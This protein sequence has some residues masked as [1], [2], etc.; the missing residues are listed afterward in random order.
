MKTTIDIALQK[1][2]Q[3]AFQHVDFVGPTDPADKVHHTIKDKIELPMNGAAVVIDVASGEV[4]ALVSVPT[5]DLNKYDELFPQLIADDLNQPMRDRALMN[6]MEPGST[7]KPIVGLGVVTQGLDTATHTIECR[8]APVIDGKMISKPR[9][10]TVSMFPRPGFTH[11]SI[12]SADPHPDGFL[13]LTDAIERSCN[14]YFVTQGDKLGVDGLSYW[15]R[16]FGFGRTTGIGLYE[17]SGVVPATAR[18]RQ[19]EQQ[20][21]AWYASIGQGPVNAT[22]IQVAGEMATIARDGIW[23]RP[24]LVPAGSPVKLPTTRVDGTEIDDRRDLHLDPAALAAVHTGMFRVVNSIGGTGTT[25]RDDALGV[26]VAAKTGSATASQLVRIKRD[27]AGNMLHEANG[28][29]AIER[30]AYGWRDAPNKELPWYRASGV[31]D[32]GV[33]KGTHSWV[34]GYMPADHPQVAFAVYVEYGNSG[35]IAAGSVVK[36]LIAA[37]VKEGYVTAKSNPAAPTPGPAPKPPSLLQRPAEEPSMTE[38]PS[39]AP[40]TD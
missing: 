37:C 14:V 11:H 9:C 32:A 21:A 35:G 26:Q 2:I 17:A 1:E 38:E 29:P 27:A 16:Q 19:G 24:R 30:I 6:A 10:W 18:V 7:A 31:N 23:L 15:M 4:R 33:A 25:V 22:P 28:K 5:Y 20:S 13:N 34:G 3:D 40:E 12:P 36:K 39:G 8:G